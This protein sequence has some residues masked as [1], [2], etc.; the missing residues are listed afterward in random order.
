VIIYGSPVGPQVVNA[1]FK[2]EAN[3]SHQNIL[4]LKRLFLVADDKILPADAKKNLAGYSISNGNDYV[5][6]KY[7]DVKAIVT[8]SDSSVHDG[9]VYKATNA[10]YQGELNGKKRWVYPIGS[11][12]Q[13]R[14]ILKNL[15]SNIDWK[16]LKESIDILG[17]LWKNVI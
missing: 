7:P 17:Q 6:K 14:W 11:K 9:T 8:Y 10:V 2:P 13:K 15:K 1:I 4:E 3:L 5:G 16:E 12:S